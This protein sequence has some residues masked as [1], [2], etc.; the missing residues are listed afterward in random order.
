[1]YDAV[2]EVTGAHSVSFDAS[3]AR[4]LAGT[5][6]TVC[7]FDVSRPGRDS[8][9]LALR[10]PEDDAGGFA[11]KGRGRGGPGRAGFAPATGRP[12]A[13]D[14]RLHGG[15]A[16]TLA[17]SPHAPDLV[18]A[19]SFSG[20]V[21]LFDLRNGGSGAIARLEDAHPAGV[22]HAC[23]S[24]DGRFL[25]TGGRRD[26]A[27]LCWDARELSGP[28]YALDRSPCAA[29]QRLFFA[30]EPGGRHLAA[31]RLDGRVAL[32][33]LAEGRA[34]AAWRVADDPV[35]AV[36]WHPT[37]GV[38][39]TGSGTRRYDLGP[40]EEEDDDEANGRSE[41]AGQGAEAAGAAASP[42]GA[43]R[44]S[45]R[46]CAAAA[47]T[48]AGANVQEDGVSQL[49]AGRCAGGDGTAAADADG[50]A[51]REPGVGTRPGP[52]LASATPVSSAGP[53]PARRPWG[54]RGRTLGPGENVLRVWRLGT[55]PIAVEGDETAAAAAGGATAED[56][57]K[58]SVGA[59]RS[60]TRRAAT[61]PAGSA[62]KKKKARLGTA[63]T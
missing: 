1:M 8:R 15:I 59:A 40:D 53:A 19:G 34:V 58:D 56:V 30:V 5:A 13:P 2:D 33:D 63:A 20:D 62:S 42:P 49:A 54:A 38:L 23:F 37:A 12:A 45:E 36:A 48:D 18:A 47:A 28:L 29:N 61:L 46:E 7:V 27:V 51:A 41:G 31:G 21:T 3:G 25:Y 35:A 4:L 24:A 16:A 22:A 55:Q 11:G 43:L 50:A 60:S 57:A 14:R 6:G 44:T 17:V 9:R 32:F 39:A 26:A 10:D 52:P